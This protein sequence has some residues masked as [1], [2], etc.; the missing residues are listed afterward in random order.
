MSTFINFKGTYWLDDY[1][2]VYNSNFHGTGKWKELK[3]D[4][5][6]NG[7]KSATISVDGKTERFMV[8]R[9]VAEYFVPNP[10]NLPCVDHYNDDR[11]DERA[12]NLRWVSVAENNQKDTKRERL[13][14]SI[15]GHRHSEESKKKMSDSQSDRE[16][17]K[18]GKLKGRKVVEI[19]LNGSKKVW[20]SCKQAADFYGFHKD[21]IAKCARGERAT[22]INGK[23][24][25]YV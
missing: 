16:R 14:N 23:K 8:H 17:E 20:D 25:E 15:K 18:D 22:A 19:D 21:T 13:K 5:S 4:Y 1:G 3:Y 7:Y 11:T 12:V 6:R 9:L 24:W 10:L 2:H